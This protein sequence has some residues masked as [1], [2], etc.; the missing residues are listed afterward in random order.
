MKKTSL[1]VLAVAGAFSAFA[2]PAE[3]YPQV[4]AD[5][6]VNNSKTIV[7]DNDGSTSADSMRR[8]MDTFYADQF[9]HVQDPAAPYFMFLS[10]NA[11]LA[12]GI[13][14][15]VML[16]GWF[17]WHTV[18]PNASFAPF[19]I[20]MHPTAAN[21]RALGATASGTKLFLRAMGMHK[22]LGRYSLYVE[23]EFSGY[24][25]SNFELKKAY[26]TI[27]DWTI[28]LASTTFSDP[29][30]LPPT[31]D[32]Q[33]PNNKIDA[34]AILVRWMHTW[35]DHWTMAASVEYPAAIRM[36][37]TEFAERCRE[38]APDLGFFFQYQWAG[39]GAQHVRLSATTRQLT[40]RNLIKKENK[41]QVG[42]GLQLSTMAS[43][44]SQLTLYGTVNGGRGIGGLGGDWIMD[45]VDFSPEI[46]DPG[47]MYMPYVFG[48][49]VGA[50]WNF[51]PRFFV[52]AVY[53]RTH[54][55]PR[56]EVEPTQYKGGHYASA[57][58]FYYL[59]PRMRIGAGYNYGRRLNADGHGRNAHRIGLIA[60]FAF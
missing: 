51:S 26:G 9:R 14:G 8:M 7:I 13:G 41:T 55:Y 19:N 29:G 4:L 18:M 5:S 27:N 60:A 30:A 40:Y 21:I 31:V 15:E 44:T 37:N 1:T 25:E 22:K 24:N 34:S 6:I 49:M 45:F 3:V 11:N 17:D 54:Y 56:H 52:D 32:R 48:F 39:I 23:G 16:R 20:N 35:K 12:M 47:T 50:Q 42:W 36:T 57:N 28:G 10:R 43:P 33:G 59:T 58:V 53:S 2:A 46:D 38:W